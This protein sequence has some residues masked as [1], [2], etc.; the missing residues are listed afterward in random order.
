MKSVVQGIQRH[1]VILVQGVDHRDQIKTQVYPLFPHVVFSELDMDMG[2]VAASLSSR[3]WCG[4]KPVVVFCRCDAS[5]KK[6]IPLIRAR[7]PEQAV[8]IVTDGE[9]SPQLELMK[10]VAD[11]K[12]YS[13]QK[14]PTIFASLRSVAPTNHASLDGEPT[15]VVEDRYQQAIACT[16]IP[17]VIDQIHYSNGDFDVSCTLS[18][19][20]LMQHRVPEDVIANCLPVR[21]SFEYKSNREIGR[22]TAENLQLLSRIQPMVSVCTNSMMSR[23]AT[24]DYLY[25]AHQIDP[26]PN[27]AQHAPDNPDPRQAK[28]LNDAIRD[29]AW[30]SGREEGN[31]KRARPQH[32]PMN[33]A[34]KYHRQS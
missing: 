8:L 15:T 20:D 27:I 24:M 32:K 25:Y 10:E 28:K 22:K 26:C 13:G 23:Y 3:T 16:S 2:T 6:I 18:D 21:A 30:K 33:G 9:W 29:L 34:S 4:K 31:S 1:Q 19:V 12:V 17:A 14:P 11:V 7:Q 5:M